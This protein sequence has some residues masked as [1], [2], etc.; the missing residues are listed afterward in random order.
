MSDVLEQEFQQ[1]L[2]P[3]VTREFG[4]RLRLWRQPVGRLE[5]KRGGWIDAAPVGAADLTGVIAP[6]GVRL[7]VEMKGAR[8]P[9]TADQVRWRETMGGSYGAATT[10]I[11]FDPRVNLDGNLAFA[12]AALRELVGQFECTHPDAVLTIHPAGGVWC[13]RCGWRNGGRPREGV[14]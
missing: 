13:T 10:Q 12:L 11:R 9:T 3:L 2:R 14:R 5:L 8:T 1:A 7:E 4:G 6:T